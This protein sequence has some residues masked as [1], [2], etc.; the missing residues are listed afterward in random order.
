MPTARRTSRAAS[1]AANARTLPTTGVY[2][3]MA[4]DIQAMSDELD[5]FQSA[6]R[7]TMSQ[8]NAAIDNAIGDIDARIQAMVKGLD[9]VTKAQVI[10]MINEYVVEHGGLTREQVQ[11][12]IDTA[13]GDAL[14][15]AY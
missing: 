9:L 15:T 1:Y 8:V 7:V 12:M 14:N 6:P 5:Q 4:A 11:E 3:D 10:Q 2:A 13:V